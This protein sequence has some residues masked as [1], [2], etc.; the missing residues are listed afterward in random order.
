MDLTIIETSKKGIDLKINLKKEYRQHYDFWTIYYDK[1]EEE[2]FNIF[3]RFLNTKNNYLDIGAWIGPTVLVGAH[4]CNHVYALEPNKIAFEELICNIS[5]NSSIKTKVTCIDA[6]LSPKNHSINLYIR[7]DPSESMSSILPNKQ[8][9]DYFEVKGI[10]FEQLLIDYEIKN[11]N[12]IKMDIEAGEYKVLPTMRNYLKKYKPTLYLSLHPQFL[13]DSAEL[14]LSQSSDRFSYI[15]SQTQKLIRSLDF[16][17]Y[18]YDS[19]GNIIDSN[20]VIKER[21]FRSYVFSNEKW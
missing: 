13:L 19:N 21:K 11:V 18:I 20:E 8:K 2:T 16:Y 17:K 9:G 6:A 5:L 4:K 10:T 12:F 14:L 7:T 1:W 15:E 3:E